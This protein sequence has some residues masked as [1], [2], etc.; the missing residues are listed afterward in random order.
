M[1]PPNGPW[2]VR[3]QVSQGLERAQRLPHGVTAR[4]STRTLGRLSGPPWKRAQRSGAR[5]AS[6]TTKEVIFIIDFL[7]FNWDFLGLSYSCMIDFLGFPRIWIWIWSYKS[8]RSYRSYKVHNRVA[9]RSSSFLGVNVGLD[10]VLNLSK[11]GL[12][13]D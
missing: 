10:R 12:K 2:G 6:G 11:S 9:N 3:E 8:Y 13:P 5:L 7:D 4:P 1:G